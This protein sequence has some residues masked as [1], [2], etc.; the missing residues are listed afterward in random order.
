MQSRVVR[1]V[2]SPS[3]PPPS[4]PKQFSDTI[5]VL[6][7]PVSSSFR[8]DTQ[9]KN[10]YFFDVHK[11]ATD[12][13]RS[14]VAGAGDI[15]GE[16]TTYRPMDSPTPMYEAMH[17][18]HDYF[19]DLEVE[20]QKLDAMLLN[21][22]S[23]SSEAVNPTGACE[24]YDELPPP[25]S[26]FT[27]TSGGATG[28]KRSN[29]VAK[30]VNLIEN[31]FQEI[32]RFRDTSVQQHGR[33]FTSS[34]A[35]SDHHSPN[36]QTG[37][38]KHNT[39]PFLPREGE[40]ANISGGLKSDDVFVRPTG[41]PPFSQ[42]FTTANRN[43]ALHRPT[44][45]GVISKLRDDLSRLVQTG[46]E[47]NNGYNRGYEIRNA[48]SLQQ[49]RKIPNDGPIPDRSSASVE[50]VLPS[51]HRSVPRRFCKVHNC[52]VSEKVVPRCPV[53]GLEETDM[54]RE[55]DDLNSLS[56]KLDR[57]L[58]SINDQNNQIEAILKTRQTNDDVLQYTDALS[59][60]TNDGSRYDGP[61]PATSLDTVITR[62]GKKKKGK[63]LSCIR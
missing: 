50:D 33:R 22:N 30:R 53:G 2:P 32:K 4:P 61:S 39:R 29:S 17:P 35:V 25:V 49:N 62:K 7:T 20:S 3:L 44:T 5:H 52:F 18:Q 19:K 23:S 38:V 8:C 43:N 56:M 28:V 14:A 48:P 54:K 55:K 16:S 9:P 31:R 27:E 12:S 37:G 34:E 26:V 60:E 45:T 46:G 40:K 36:I 51:E 58:N 63:L 47:V 59:Q 1:N 15:Q 10:E 21:M 6:Q 11:E 42:T 13:E 41:L 57:L 24:N